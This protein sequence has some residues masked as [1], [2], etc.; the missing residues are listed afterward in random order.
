MD[1]LLLNITLRDLLELLQKIDTA[2]Y[3]QKNDMLGNTSIGQ[4]VRHILELTECLL[5]DYESGHIYYDVRKRDIRVEEDLS[6]AIVRAE[7]LRRNIH[8]PDKPLWLVESDSQRAM[9]P[10]FYSR[11]IVYH[12]EHAIHHMALI[13]VGLREQSL[14][15]VDDRFGMAPATL[16]Y[17]KEQG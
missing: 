17:R 3:V 4:H 2:A 7:A 10:S 14:E 8:L 16:K 5:R 13:R 12:A 1:D 15:I 6:V 9:V 11:E